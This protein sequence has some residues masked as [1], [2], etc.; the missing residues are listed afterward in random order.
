MLTAF[1]APVE[2]LR[3]VSV[4][5]LKRGFAKPYYSSVPISTMPITEDEM[6]TVLSTDKDLEARVSFYLAQMLDRDFRVHVTLGT[7]IFS[8]DAT[9]RRTGLVSNLV[10]EGFGVNQ[11]I[12]ILAKCL[13]RDAEWLC[14]EEPEIHLH[15]TA[16]RR[17]ARVLTQIMHDEGKRFIISTHSE[18]FLLALLT[19]VAEKQLAP[20]D[21]AC[22]LVSKENKHTHFERQRV[23]EQGQ[24][25]GGLTS[26]I[27]GELE[28]LKAFLHV[29]P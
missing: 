12:Y 1:N 28:D 19:L 26:F 23:N 5:P 29:A 15:T 11:I 14:V 6:A 8:L 4:V 7:A 9:D 20:S 21:L 24:I 2:T 25:E 18:A 17:L 3:R 10:N 22:Y 16:V 13:H 27:E